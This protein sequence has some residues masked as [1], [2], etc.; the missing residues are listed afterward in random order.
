[1]PTLAV[2]AVTMM[3]TSPSRAGAVALLHGGLTV[4]HLHKGDRAMPMAYWFTIA[5]TRPGEPDA[6]DAAMP[7]VRFDVRELPAFADV[8]GLRSGD[9]WSAAVDA[10]QR[11][12]DARQL[13]AEGAVC[14]L[15]DRAMTAP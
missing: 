9:H 1:M 11:A 2:R 5:P 4:R 3:P 12:I 15:L 14:V 10:M 13:T 6:P 7:V 8:I